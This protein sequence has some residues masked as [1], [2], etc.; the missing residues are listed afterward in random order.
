MYALDGSIELDAYESPP[1]DLGKGLD[2]AI[3]H[4][5]FG[6]AI[7]ASLVHDNEALLVVTA[8]EQRSHLRRCVGHSAFCGTVE[9]AATSVRARGA[10]IA[11]TRSKGR[12]R[13]T[14]GRE[15]GDEATTSIR[16]SGEEEETATGG[17]AAREAWAKGGT[18]AVGMARPKG[19]RGRRGRR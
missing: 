7:G 17:G 16:A 13:V 6:G 18:W 8:G 9:E 19:R 2:T 3:N 5:V 10:A 11:T 12:R 4:L 15:R 14:Q 1:N